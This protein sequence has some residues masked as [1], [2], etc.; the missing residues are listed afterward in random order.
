MVDMYT[1]LKIPISFFRLRNTLRKGTSEVPQLPGD[2]LFDI[3][4]RLQ[5]EDVVQLKRVCKFWLQGISSRE[6]P[7]YHLRHS[8][9]ETRMIVKRGGCC[10]LDFSGQREYQDYSLRHFLRQKI[11]VLDSLDGLVL[12]YASR[13]NNLCI[14]NPITRSVRFLTCAPSLVGYQKVSY[15]VIGL[16]YHGQ[17]NHF[18]SGISKYFF[19]PVSHCDDS[20]QKTA[21]LRKVHKRF[22]H[23]MYVDELAPIVVNGVLYW[24]ARRGV[25]AVAFIQSMDVLDLEFKDRLAL[26]CQPFRR[27]HYTSSKLFE[28]K[29]KGK[30]LL[31]ALL[32]TSVTEISIWIVR[33]SKAGA[34]HDWVKLHKISFEPIWSVEKSTCI[35]PRWGHDRNGIMLIRDCHSSKLLKIFLRLG[36]KLFLYHPSD[37]K[38]KEISSYYPTV[39]CVHSLITFS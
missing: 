29:H 32:P 17:F 11:E 16:W 31:G 12:F 1:R 28:M 15:K 2:V 27:N 19:L 22:R 36:G 10:S 38:L 9:L 4:R 5:A 14:C 26:P 8:K 18:S 25:L 24:I 3:F 21:N 20:G 23:H 6:F 34:R 30:S 13:R 39:T 7:Q 35:V 33:H 37:A